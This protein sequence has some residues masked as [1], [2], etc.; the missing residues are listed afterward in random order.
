MTEHAERLNT[1]HLELSILADAIGHTLQGI[2]EPEGLSA[3]AYVLR[4][5]L[6]ELVESCP[7]P[8]TAPARI[9]PAPDLDLSDIDDGLTA[10]LDGVPAELLTGGRDD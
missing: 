5:R 4:T 10:D 9:V 3:T 8:D 7:F 1:W 6:E 2:E